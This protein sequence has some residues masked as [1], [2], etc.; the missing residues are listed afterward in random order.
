MV[1]AA[2][3]PEIRVQRFTLTAGPG[4]AR[5]PAEQPRRRPAP[6]HRARHRTADSV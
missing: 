2:A 5:S 3:T 1:G 4:F 6:A